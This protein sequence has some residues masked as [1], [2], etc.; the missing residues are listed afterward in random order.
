MLLVP[1]EDRG[2]WRRPPLLIVALLLANT[3]IHMGTQSAHRDP[4]YQ[5]ESVLEEEQI[6]LLTE[7]EWPLFL[8]W[9]EDDNPELWLEARD[10]EPANR[11]YLLENFA[12][13]DL[14]FSRYV[15]DYWQ[16]NDPSEQ[17][18]QARA[19]VESWRARLPTIRWGLIPDDADLV[20]LFSH[21][22]MH[23]SWMHLFGNMLFL[24]LFGVP[25]ERH[26]GALR[27]G[28]L[29]LLTGL[30]AVSLYMAT[31][32][33]ST[34][35]LVG[36]SGAISGLMGIYCASYGLRRIEFFYTLGFLFGS[37][38]APA[39]AVF[40]L[41]LGWE[42]MQAALFDSQVAYMAHAGGL[43]SGVVVT[44]ALRKLWPPRD[45]DEPAG[46]DPGKQVAQSPSDTVPRAIERLADALEFDQAL[47]LSLKRL[48]EKPDRPALWRAAF[49]FLP[50]ASNRNAGQLLQLAARKR[51]QGEISDRLL[52]DIW[53][54]SRAPGMETGDPGA[55]ALLIIAE[56]LSRLGQQE[57]AR[58]LAEQ[59]ERRG[60]SHP[61]LNTLR[62]RLG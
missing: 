12:W 62:S 48:D 29:Y 27:L 33:G 8:D 40:P 16:G 47:S 56:S 5:L 43:I 17:W 2:N 50:H 15:H 36:A 54:Q 60:I 37:F 53:K 41:W 51:H 39:L 18:R 4:A 49:E 7:K 52:G 44:L 19:G 38:R 58:E 35:P 24:L 3:F 21:M 31:N 20:S 42:L 6:E 46:G 22:F 9:I 14:G 25:M 11:T 32:R 13:Y 1:V 26:W 23:G 55:A 45:T 30:G 28:C 57:A 10:T 61:R 34:V 59:M